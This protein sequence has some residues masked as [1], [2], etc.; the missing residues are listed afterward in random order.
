[1]SAA[2]HEQQLVPYAPSVAG[3][4]QVARL[5]AGWQASTAAMGHGNTREDAVPGSR[6]A[7]LHERDQLKA[8]LRNAEGQLQRQ[9]HDSYSEQASP[10]VQRPL[11]C[12][13]CACT[14]VWWWHALH[15]PHR[16]GRLPALLPS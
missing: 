12:A 3:P 15:S 4:G 14:A 5:P 13:G 8:A 10:Q 2:G 7:L 16:Q 11:T 9:R 6:E 1:M